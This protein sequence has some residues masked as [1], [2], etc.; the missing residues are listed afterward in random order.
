MNSTMKTNFNALVENNLEE[1]NDILPLDRVRGKAVK[2]LKSKNFPTAKVEKWKYFDS[3]N[4]L[5][6]EY[7][8]NNDLHTQP[9]NLDFISKL[10]LSNGKETIVFKN[11]NCSYENQ[12]EKLDNGV[13]FGSLKGANEKYP[14]LVNEYIDRLNSNS[15][16]FLA[17]NS[18]LALDGY[19]IFIPKSV[20]K[21]KFHIYEFFDLNNQKVS[22]MRN[23]ILAESGSQAD[24]TFFSDSSHDDLQF[25]MSISEIFLSE[26]SSIQL[27]VIQDHKGNTDIINSYFVQQKQSSSFTANVITTE[28]K[29]TRNEFIIDLDFEDA[30]ADIKGAY[31]L[32]RNDKLENRVEINHNSPECNSNQLFKGILNGDSIGTFVGK[33]LVNKNSQKT[34]A[35]QSTKNIILS[36]NARANMN[37]F[38]EIYADDVKCSHGA[39]VGTID[40]NALFYLQ[41]RGI[42]KESAKKILLNSF[43]SDIIEQ[44]GEENIVKSLTDD[45]FA[46]LK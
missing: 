35:Y 21:I 2:D 5:Q 37:P 7:F 46:K 30:K 31:I 27:N 14:Q 44:I 39:S 13:I 26:N 43:L 41:S 42:D 22:S 29:N 18:S 34:E 36:E 4:L 11:G 16:Y 25:A 6:N 24:I 3:K 15:N 33:I 19:F 17:L 38:L 45:I 23:L 1:I 9:L 28:S 32:D 10:D 12:I 20:E 40:E 8:I